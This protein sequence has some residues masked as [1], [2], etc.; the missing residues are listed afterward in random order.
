MTTTA[1]LAQDFLDAVADPS[2]FCEGQIP[3][4]CPDEVVTLAPN[5][6]VI[7]EC[8][9]FL[10]PSWGS[11]IRRWSA[12]LGGD[13]AEGCGPYQW[14]RKWNRSQQYWVVQFAGHAEQE[15][16][17]VDAQHAACTA[18]WVHVVGGSPIDKTLLFE[19]RYSVREG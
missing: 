12:G 8:P 3:V 9:L 18:W 17:A 4:F 7:D 11:I 1:D 10:A 19:K 2:V 13:P 14:L 15:V 6:G 16:Q 5:C